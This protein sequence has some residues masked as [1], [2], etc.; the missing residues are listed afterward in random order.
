MTCHNCRTEC[1]RFGKHRNGL[2]RYQCKSVLE[3]LHRAARR[4][5]LTAC[6]CLSRRPRWF[7]GSCSK[8][9]RV[10][11][12]ERVTDVHH[13]TI[14][15]LLVLAGEKCERIMAE[16][17]RNVEVR[18]VECDEALVLHRQKAKAGAARGRSESSATATFSLRIERHTKL[19]LNIAMGK[20]RPSAPRT[21]SLKASATR[22]HGLRSRS[23]R[24]DSRLTAPRSPQRC[25]TDSPA[26]H[27][28]S[29]S[30]GYARGR[31]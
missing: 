23:P 5:R 29:R 26:S 14:L 24:M 2:Q 19:V 3:D 27:N 7:S 25:T 10:S 20:P 11:S 21:P 6:T 18:D 31:S 30:I 4:R 8:A 16:K 13:S 15:K 28:S 9:T 12:V 22:Q 17:I 1:Q